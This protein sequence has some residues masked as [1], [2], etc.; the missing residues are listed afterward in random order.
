MLALQARAEAISLLD[1]DV[2]IVLRFGHCL[3]AR[4]FLGIRY[5]LLEYF[6]TRIQPLS[7]ACQVTGQ[8]LDFLLELLTLAVGFVDSGFVLRAHL[9]ENFGADGVLRTL[10]FDFKPLDSEA[11]AFALDVPSDLRILEFLLPLI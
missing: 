2:Q 6:D 1:L 3:P 4:C 7:L 5:G 8:G 10:S 9:L 11:Q